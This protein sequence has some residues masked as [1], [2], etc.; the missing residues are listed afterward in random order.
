MDDGAVDIV[1]PSSGMVK[2]SITTA[3]GRTGWFGGTD[4]A[5]ATDIK[6][7]ATDARVH[8]MPGFADVRLNHMFYTETLWMLGTEIT[9]G[10][11][12]GTFKA[13]GTVTRQAMAAFKH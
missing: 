11:G 9:T 6:M 13:N 12:E 1:G 10:F 8:V 3:E 2:F 4:Y 7:Q 5:T